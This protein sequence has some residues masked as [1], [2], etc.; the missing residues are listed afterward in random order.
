MSSAPRLLIADHRGEGLADLF[1]ALDRRGFQ[2]V[3]AR[4]AR[5]TVREMQ[6]VRPDLIVIDPLVAGG[7]AELEEIRRLAIGGPPIPV[8]VVADPAD[9]RPAA[10]ALEILAPAPRDLV[11]RSAPA[12]EYTLRIEALL[13]LAHHAR[14]TEELRHRALHD[15]RTDLLRPHAF[16]Q[17]L[18]EHFSAAQ[19]H[20]FEMALVVIDLDDFGFVNKRFDHTIGDLLIAKVGEVIRL[21]LRTED[22]AGRVGGDEFAALLPYTGR[23]DAAHVVRRLRDAIAKL[24]GTIATEAGAVEISAS[25]G[26]ETFDGTDV[27]TVE[28]LRLHAEIALRE[29][30]R[31]GGHRAVYYRSLGAHGGS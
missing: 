10:R 13:A 9:P 29:A 30:K 20:R 14:E 27:D 21:T 28:N 4:Q 5:D 23:V 22:V 1:Q 17:R 8:L 11:H 6:R 25:L 3:L 12:E 24:S 19:R 2:P 31:A 18:T 7:R 26:F 15:D 16:E